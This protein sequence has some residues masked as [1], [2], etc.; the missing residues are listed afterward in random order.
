MIKS[1]DKLTQMQL[2][3]LKSFRHI[4]DETQLR[5]VKS[6]LNFYFKKK[7]EEAILTE[8]SERGYTSE[9]YEAWLAHSTKK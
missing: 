9:V 7:L 2:E 3:L 1:E 8:E 5:E 6:L 4:K